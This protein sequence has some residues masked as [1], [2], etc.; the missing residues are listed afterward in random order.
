LSIIDLLVDSIVVTTISSAR[1]PVFLHLYRA[2]V[3]WKCH[4]SLTPFSPSPQPLKAFQDL[5]AIS[6]LAVHNGPLRGLIVQLGARQDTAF[7][8]HTPHRDGR[9]FT[10]HAKATSISAV[11]GLGDQAWPYICDWDDDGDWDMLIGG[12]IGWPRILVNHGTHS[13]PAFSEAQNIRSQGR[14]IR[15]R[16]SQVFPGCEGYKHDMGYTYPK[17]IDWDGDGLKD[18]ML[19]NIT[20]RIFWYKNI[21]TKKTPK[22]GL[23][24]Q[25]LPDGY[26][27]TD[28]TLAVTGQYLMANWESEPQADQP[29][30]WRTG[31][32]FADFNNDRL[33]DMITLDGFT[34]ELQLFRQYKD[35]TGRL[36]LK[37]GRELKLT[38]GRVISEKVVGRKKKHWTESFQCCDWDNDGLIDIMYSLAG[39]HGN[40]QDGGSI[41]LLRNRGTKK[42]PM[43]DKPRTMSCFGSPIMITSHG[44]HPGVG[45]I[46]GDGKPDILTC[47]EDSIYAFFSHIALEMPNRPRYRLSQL[48]KK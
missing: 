8:I 19:P 12:G 39:G 6:L 27:E 35:D 3:L 31:A 40:M 44:P 22:F 47:H 4:S 29:F 32:G 28:E 7:F 38:D 43:F 42:E 23:R 1:R 5:W 17:F 37:E 36:R 45:D 10:F 18:L 13:R 15:I 25:I 26:T 11:M 21:G 46:N 14:P 33:M 2:L 41:Y 9:Y 48:I 30:W 34:R 24:R 20:N 16:M